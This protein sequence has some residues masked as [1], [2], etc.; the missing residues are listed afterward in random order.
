MGESP[1]LTQTFINNT[2]RYIIIDTETEYPNSLVYIHNRKPEM[3]AMKSNRRV[4]CQDCKCIR[5]SCWSHWRGWCK[6][7]V[8]G[9]YLVLASVFLS[10]MI[11]QIVRSQPNRAKHAAWFVGG[12]CVLLTLPVFLAGLLQ[13]IINYTRPNLQ[14]HIIRWVL[15][16]S[17][18]L[19]VS[20]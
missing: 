17:C 3:I 16:L 13:H 4:L 8:A 18:T 20:H 12:V 11:Y 2:R 6:R 1:S 7:V 15:V 9:V 5:L 10:L 14:K 19:Q